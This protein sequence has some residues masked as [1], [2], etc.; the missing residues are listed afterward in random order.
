MPVSTTT[1][2]SLVEWAD[3]RRVRI[4]PGWLRHVAD[5]RHLPSSVLPEPVMWTAADFSEP[6]TLDGSRILEDDDVLEQWL[7]TLVR[8]GICRLSG[9][10]TDL[11]FVGRLVVARRADPRLQLRAG[12]ERARQARS[13]LDRVHRARPRS[14]HRPADA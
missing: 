11:D 8:Y 14:A 3:G 13:R 5:E 9:T 4:H 1:V 12:V 6:P 10:P 7:A 2:R